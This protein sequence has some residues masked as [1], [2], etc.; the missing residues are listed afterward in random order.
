[1]WQDVVHRY[2]RWIGGLSHQSSDLSHLC[3]PLQK[4]VIHALLNTRFK[5]IQV[6]TYLANCQTTK[7][8][9]TKVFPKSLGGCT[10]TNKVNSSSRIYSCSTRGTNIAR[11]EGQWLNNETQLCSARNPDDSPKAWACFPYILP[12]PKRVSNHCDITLWHH[13]HLLYFFHGKT[14][15]MPNGNAIIHLHIHWYLHQN[16]QL[17]PLHLNLIVFS[18]TWIS[19]LWHSPPGIS[20]CP[21]TRALNLFTTFK[22]RYKTQACITN[23]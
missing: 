19:C 9:L 23:N 15:H 12:S 1:M 5:G 7:V 14:L 18:L 13:N 10:W 20:V 2:A 17:L 6:V 21:C 11:V 4:V 8:M 3:N 16:P 22:D